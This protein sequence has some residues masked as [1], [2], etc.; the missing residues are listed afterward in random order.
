MATTG[1]PTCSRPELPS[2]AGTSTPGI[3]VGRMAAMSFFGSADWSVAADLV[4]SAKVTLMPAAPDTTCSA[5]RMT[6]CALATTP[7][8]LPMTCFFAFSDSMVTTDGAT[9]EKISAAVSGVAE[10]DGEAVG[11]GVA[12]PVDPG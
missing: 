2:T 9:A 11:C 5:V 10:G 3:V 8:P 6:P 12:E 1:S 4:P 7:V